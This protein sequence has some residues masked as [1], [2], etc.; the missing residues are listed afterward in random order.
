MN[1]GIYK[2]LDKN[3]EDNK[4]LQSFSDSKRNIILLIFIFFIVSFF[5]GTID[6][7]EEQFS[8]IPDVKSY[9]LMAEASPE[10]STDAGKPFA[11]RILPPFIAGFFSDIEIGF[12]IV[13]Y[14][15]ISVLLILFYIMLIKFRIK[16]N[17]AFFVSILLIF[18]KFTIGF[19]TWVPYYISDI[20]VLIFMLL[21]LFI[22]LE[23]RSWGVF[24]LLLIFGV[25]SRETAFFILP[26]IFIYLFEKK[27]LKENF[28]KF[29]LSIIPAIT[30]F[31]LIRYNITTDGTGE[32][33]ILY[34]FKNTDSY[35]SEKIFDPIKWY[36]LLINTFAPLSLLPII[37]FSKTIN[38]FKK[39]IYLLVYL[40]IFFMS[41]FIANDIERL[42]VPIFFIFY[43][44]IAK[45]F[46]E[47]IIEN[48]PIILITIILVA[49]NILH[50]QIGVFT[51]PSKNYSAIL[52]VLTTA[53]LTVSVF[54]YKFK[55]NKSKTLGYPKC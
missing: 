48:R 50:H 46:Q 34:S 11:Y 17:I 23:K 37:Y 8:K 43:I 53:V 3:N 24:S 7:T 52:S 42:I 13:A 47:E 38:F 20:F 28:F 18:N 31:L 12:K 51:L 44:L 6:L 5:Y 39:N 29:F 10:F 45:I 19:Y 16:D 27:L 55:K 9:T 26:V 54:T 35:L 25:I 2:L 1:K 41:T 40:T 4:Y 36:K 15:S 21:S 14:F 33:G 22:L 32:K 30:I 49:M